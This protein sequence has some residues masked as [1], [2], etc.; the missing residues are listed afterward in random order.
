M[1]NDTMQSRTATRL[2]RLKDL[3][4]YKVADG[5]VDPR[6]WK[7]ISADRMECGKVDSLITDPVAMKVRYLDVELDKKKLKLDDSRHVLVPIGGATL[8]DKEDL[9]YLGTLTAEKLASLPPFDHDNITREDEIALRRRLDTQFNPTERDTDFYSHAHFD[10]RRFF[11]R[12][13][14]GRET[15]AYVIKVG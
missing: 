4:D 3:D 6:G 1:L 2:A 5:D 12:R 8:D 7:V 10:D 11:G 14:P 9:V 13:R 15:T